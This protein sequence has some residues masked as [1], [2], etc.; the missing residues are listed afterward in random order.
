MRRTTRLARAVGLIAV[1]WV[2]AVACGGGGSGGG[3]NVGGGEVGEQVSLAGAVITV[4][5]KEFTEQLVLGEI[6]IQALE[7]AGATVERRT[8]MVGTDAVRQALLGGMSMSTGSTPG[9]RGLPSWATRRPCRTA[10]DSPR[11]WPAR[12]L[13]AMG[14]D[15]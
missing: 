4:S 14:S 11:P 5:S 7:N 3:G 9:P 12:T 13:S 8:G 2:L 1:A 15:G 10:V 6:A